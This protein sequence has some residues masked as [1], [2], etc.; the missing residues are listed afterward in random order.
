MSSSRYR[1]SALVGAI[2]LLGGC[3]FS[4]ELHEGEAELTSVSGF[5]A[6]AG[7]LDMYVYVPPGVPANAPLVV[8]MHGCTQTAADIERTGWNELADTLG[9]YLV[10]PEQTSGNNPAGCFNWAGEYGDETNLVRG[11]GENQSII[12]MVDYMKATYDIDDARVFAVG[13]SAG[14][15]MVPVMLATYPDVFA[16]GAINAGVPYRCAT[17]VNEA[18]SCMNTGKNLGP[19]AGGDLVRRAGP[20][21]YAGPYP[22]VSIWAGS[23]DSTV[24]PANVPELVDQWTDVLGA[25]Q[26][27]DVSATIDGASY[28]GFEDA[29]GEI[30]VESYIVPGMGHAV[31]R[32]ASPLGSCGST[33]AFISDVGICASY[34]QA[35]F[36]GLDRRDANPPTVDL[37]TPADGDVVRGDVTVRAVIMDDEALARA[38][39]RVDGEVRGVA[40]LTGLM[41]DVSFTWDSSAELDGS[42]RLEVVGFDEAGNVMSVAAR[43]IVE[44]GV[45]DLEPPSVAANPPGQRFTAD[46]EVEL[47]SDEDATVYFTLD[48]SV[49][50]TTSTRYTG[51]IAITESATLRFFA[52]DAAGNASAVVSEVYERLS[53][54]EELMG[55]CTDHL[56]AGRVDSG[57]YLD[58]ASV[59]GYLNPI[60][61]YRFGEC[62]SFDVSGAGCDLSAPA[63]APGPGPAPAPV[64]GPVACEDIAAA[65]YT[66]NGA[67][68]ATVVVVGGLVTY[69]AVGSGET[70]PGGIL[71][72]TTLRTTDAGSSWAVGACP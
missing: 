54:D 32:G 22:R 53:Y 29:S 14:A 68:R 27:P 57:G 52:V 5:G 4:A 12:S 71:G 49:P 36:F 47:T 17:S 10:Y 63:P 70:L 37:L 65:N 33:G 9:F 1:V 45:P 62:Y 59:A 28:E 21:G 66:H 11:R 6:N 61:M 7:A 51:P 43:V 34:R 13:F 69:Q 55:T 72:N 46:L 26:S 48:G 42:R 31:A 3:A 50:D 24:V 25:D 44:G 19:A 56:V 35:L 16:G 23:S 8:V 18:F 64:P 40:A 2:A 38:E 20:S 39:L 67:G 41:E 30:V 15:A 58:C 60:A